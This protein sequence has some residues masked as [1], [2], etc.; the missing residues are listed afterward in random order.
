M[1]I[2]LAVTMPSH[3]FQEKDYLN[4]RYFHKRAYY[5]ACIASSIEE[6][7]DSSFAINFALQDDNEL[8]PIIIV[9]PG[10]GS[11]DFTN[12]KCQIR[13]IL[14]AEGD[15]F[16]I[17]KTLPRKNALRSKAGSSPLENLP[18]PIYNASIRS[19]CSSRAYLKYLNAASLQSTAFADA[20]TLG[21]VWLRQRGLQCGGFGSFEWACTTA[22]LMQSG[23]PQGRALLSKGYSNYQLFK[24][25]IQFLATRDLVIS[26]V[27][28]LDNG[29]EIV[30][31][32]SDR[33]TLFDGARGLNI[34][35]KMT[36]WSYS[37][38]KHEASRTLKL[39]NDP[40][41]DQFDACFITK[42]DDFLSRFDCVISLPSNQPR[43]S[44]DSVIDAISP[45]VVYCQELYQILKTG[46]GDRAQLIHLDASSRTSWLPASQRPVTS[47]DDHVK[48]G[49][50]MNPE[51][52]NRT[53]D[54]GPVVEDKEVAAAFRKFWGD[55]AELR[56]FKDGA[57]QE[58]LI[59]SSSDSQ[60]SRDS[61]LKQIITYIIQRHIGYEATKGMKFMGES[62]DHMLPMNRGAISDPVVL[63]QPTMSAF[64]ALE[65]D[66]R[67]LE[68]LPLQIRQI[69]AADS[70]LRYASLKVPMSESSQGVMN[71]ADV[72]LQ[73]EGSSRWPDNLSAIQRTKIAFLL[74]IS[75][76]LEEA[77]SDLIARVGLENS[78]NHLLNNAFL[79]VIYPSG[80]YF[81]LRIHHEREV[82]LLERTLKGD[83][84]AAANREE[85]AFAHA[86]YKRNFIQAPLHT[87]AVR[88]LSTRF[89]LL[90]ASI[91]ITKQWRDSH[92]LS[93]HVS[94]EL[95]ELLTIRTFIHPHP[96]S[97][98][99]SIMTGF[100]R[101]MHL[102]AK[103]DWRLEPLIVDFNGEMNSQDID[104]IKLRF[105]AWR[106]IDPA[107]N[108]VAMF[109]ASN[110]DR[111]GVTW[112]EPG[113]S[114]VV[115]ARF[116]GLAKA[117]CRVVAEQGFDLQPE[118]LF[119]LS[120]KDYDFVIHLNPEVTG[121]KQST[122]TKAQSV[123]KNLQ[124]QAL[125]DKSLFSYNPAQSY[126][127]ELKILYDSNILFFHGGQGC[128]VV[129]GLWNPQTGPR[130]WK[131]NLQYST[132][133][134]LRSKNDEDGAQVGLNKTAT[135]HDISRLGG[136][137]IRRIE[138]KE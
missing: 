129:G 76:L 83:A 44:L 109:A 61:V 45:T 122:R 85:I 93:G 14:A 66:V 54:R 47:G 86:T 134:F 69:S 12:S 43:P 71:P 62:F 123:F 104:A 99:G 114:K 53:V 100:L 6:G 19:E 37:L 56:R 13:I 119:T 107:M 22:L 117:A 26:P 96:W 36:P 50:L 101:T 82:N 68:G 40:I 135:L 64:E 34:L 55:K 75:E 21:S 8:Q 89:P 70:Q 60:N 29:T 7:D 131:V 33:P 5:L 112:T 133:P 42:V 51:Q 32:E 111:D 80:T 127:D 38:L 73:F 78:S 39:L 105:E 59:W 58:S 97:V 4:Y 95:I 124:T 132:I 28:I 74:K 24:A 15:I 23:G 136:D 87:Q 102:I 10:Q 90:S 121:A 27:L 57:I 98:P 126:L 11:D 52:V 113:P 17:S 30:S 72:C 41:S 20:C 120:M 125:E 128:S 106:K 65:K 110:V 138:V 79:D 1:S 94:D 67:D 92:L 84:S 137:M 2:D 81:R 46:L 63:Y 18:T 35:Y 115:A 31:S 91:R 77:I 108:R 3:I 116:T 130:P 25:A 9:N 48:V 88:T 103:W 16:P 118:A 49:L